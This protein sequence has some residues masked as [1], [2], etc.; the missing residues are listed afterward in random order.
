MSNKPIADSVNP[1][2]VGPP[3]PLFCAIKIAGRRACIFD[4][5]GEQGDLYVGAVVAAG[6]AADHVDDYMVLTPPAE[7]NIVPFPVVHERVLQGGAL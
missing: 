5:D 6:W 2:D 3:R 7:S 1:P 4:Y